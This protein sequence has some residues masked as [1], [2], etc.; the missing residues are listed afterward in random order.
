MGRALFVIIAL[1]SA[2]MAAMLTGTIAHDDFGI[3]M[4]TIRTDALSAAGFI[5][6][7]VAWRVLVEAAKVNCVRSTRGLLA[8]TLR[9]RAALCRN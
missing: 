2:A 7:A 8:P 3:S 4:D 5:L 6:A 9:W 1:A